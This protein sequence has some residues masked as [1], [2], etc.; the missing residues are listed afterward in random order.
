MVGTSGVKHGA[1]RQLWQGPL[2]TPPGDNHNRAGPDWP[3]R[4]P[5]HQLPP[6]HLIQ[7]RSRHLHCTSN[8]IPHPRSC[9]APPAGHL[10]HH[11]RQQLLA[12]PG[13]GPLPHTPHSPAPPPPPAA[14]GTAVTHPGSWPGGRCRR[15]KRSHGRQCQ[16]G[17]LAGRPPGQHLQRMPGWLVWLGPQVRVPEGPLEVWGRGTPLL[18][19]SLAQGWGWLV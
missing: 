19:M 13:S 17:T 16:L 4:D 6:T 11:H 10:P 3:T 9:H 7:C 15:H 5:P 2:P 1:E 18:V 12:G 14:C 8:R